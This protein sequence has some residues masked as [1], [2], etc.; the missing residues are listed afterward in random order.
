MGQR[1][2]SIGTQGRADGKFCN[3]SMREIQACNP[4]K[5]H[6]PPDGCVKDTEPVHCEFAEWSEWSQCSATCGRGQRIHT[7]QIAV[8]A[9]DGGRGCSGPMQEVSP[10]TVTEC[11][12]K[13]S[14]D[15]VWN[16]WVEWSAC[17]KCAGQ[18]FRTRSIKVMNEG[19]GKPCEANAGQ[20]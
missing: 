13:P 4:V 18:Q 5:G 2:R 9:A 11:E 20:E 16:D 3:N 8:Q 15:C 6:D 1:S 12:V 14:K 19:E 7:R 17:T 10:C